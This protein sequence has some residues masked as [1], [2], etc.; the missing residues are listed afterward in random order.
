M[1]WAMSCSVSLDSEKCVIVNAVAAMPSRAPRP[2]TSPARRAQAATSLARTSRFEIIEA[3][4]TLWRYARNQFP[5]R[6]PVHRLLAAV[7]VFA[8][9]GSAQGSPA[10]PA[11][12]PDPFERFNRGNF[13]LSI[14][15]DK[16]LIRP[17]S[18]VSSGLTPGPIGRAIHNVLRTLNEPIVILNDLLQAHP[19][20]AAKTAGRL[21]VNVTVGL[22][23]TVDVA[24][25]L[26]AP[27]HPNGFG[28]TLGHYG[29]KPGPYL[30]LPVLGPSDVRD[31]FGGGVDMVS[32]PIF[33][34]RYAYKNEVLLTLN[35]VGGLNQRAMV[36]SELKTLLAD[37]ADPYATLRSTYLQA[38]QG[39]I[40]GDQAPAALPD[41]G[42]PGPD[43]GMP[44]TLPP[45]QSEPTA[46]SSLGEPGLPADQTDALHPLP[47]QKSG[48]PDNDVPPSLEE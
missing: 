38:R 30:Y 32:T 25:K 11:R 19:A 6:L 27:Y 39:E 31:L 36:D 24:K 15:L 2:A 35:I 22:V 8:A 5:P 3:T 18:R 20:R 46:P 26:G 41:I 1:V 21:M 13:A 23:G 17:L 45:I 16:L 42:S 14:R 44:A 48:N 12:N 33:F 28:D 40:D 34:V 47:D 37:A 29:V 10:A 43:A 9:A 7:I 4:V